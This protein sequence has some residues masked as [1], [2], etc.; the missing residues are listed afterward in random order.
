MLEKIENAIKSVISTLQIAKLYGTTHAK[1]KKFLDKAYDDLRLALSDRGELVIGIIGDE[2]AFEK[3]ILFD[4]SRS[5]RPMIA[6]LKQRE[7]ERI[8][9]S[10]SL[11]KEELDGFFTFLMRPKDEVKNDETFL[12]GLC[13]ISAGRIKVAGSDAEAPKESIES[14]INYLSLYNSS[15]DNVSNSLE[16]V[17]NFQSLDN[18]NLK[19]NVTNIF[20]NLISRHQEL[21]KLA[22]VKR[23]D[24]STFVHIL[25]VS[26]LSMCFSA[27]LGFS[28]DEV[29]EI[30]IAALF[31]DIGKMYISRKIIKKTD[32]LTDDEFDKIRS[33]SVLGAE[34][35][36]EYVDNLGSMPVIV[37]FEHHLRADGKGYPK[38][39]FPH[40]PHIAS[41]I[42]T[43]CDVYDALFSR[44][45]YKNS[46]PA[47]M[48]HSIMT[49]ER[50][51]YY[52]PAL[53]DIFFKIVGVWPIG[54]LLALSD[55]RAAVVRDENEDEIFLPVVEVVSGA[56]AEHVLIDMR[57]VRDTLK[58][59]KSL[60]PQSDG[61][62]YL[63]FI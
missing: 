62:E 12:P 2:L 60:D 31:H 5:V 59:V 26:I 56:E 22:V 37:A 61:K 11:D 48:I 35:L 49:R 18:V 17:L 36:L 9:F 4:M 39:A 24:M 3:E 53:L 44:R 28:K 34:L 19:F 7:I 52:E 57:D 1:Y 55:G 16:N 54:T 23:F 32:K 41:Q 40:V 46:Y 63:K 20:E 50:E 13:T 21:L 47:D 10:G 15:L 43:I 58:I 29:L 38:L 8:S 14:A 30:G 6:Y 42:V 27:K 33:H 51:K 25:N 45:S